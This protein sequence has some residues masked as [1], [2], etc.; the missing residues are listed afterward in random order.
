M[1]NTSLIEAITH[2]VEQHLADKPDIFLVHLYIKPKNN[3]KVYIDG[4]HGVSIGSLSSFNKSLAKDIEESA[5]FPDGDFSLEVSS[6]GLDEPLRLHRQY[7]KNIG[8]YVEVMD[9]DGIK[10]EGK[11]LEVN[12]N[13]ILI[14]HIKG[15]GK[16]QEIVNVEIPF[17]K[18]KTTKI[19][20]K[21]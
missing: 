13:D 10:T 21:F 15:K 1:E 2:K 8:R 16:K 4:D 20:I 9:I 19:Q 12:D 7:L 17:D 6:P 18:I 11:L 14:E 3:V 5:L